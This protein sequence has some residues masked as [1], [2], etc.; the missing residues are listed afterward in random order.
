MKFARTVEEILLEQ[1]EAQLAT[2][3]SRLAASRELGQVRAVRESA[4]E[5]RRIKAE[6]RER[7]AELRRQGEPARLI[8]RRLGL[9]TR[10]VHAIESAFRVRP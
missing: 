3:G 1:R 2:A 7:I 5:R 9:S 4:A 6:R 8:A 10:Q